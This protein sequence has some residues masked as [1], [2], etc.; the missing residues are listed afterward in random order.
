MKAPIKIIGLI[1][2]IALSSCEKDELE[3][4][5]NTDSGLISQ[6]LF[7]TELFYEYTY[8]ESNQIVEEKSKLHYTKHNYKENK[9]AS[10]DYYIDPGMYSSCS[11]IVDS[12][13]N[14]KEWVNPTNTEKD[15][16]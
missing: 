7:D 16:R 4:C 8:N 10:S 13:M 1:L 3:I 5:N 2:L 12:A 14:R 6:V 15:S 9:L 11:Y